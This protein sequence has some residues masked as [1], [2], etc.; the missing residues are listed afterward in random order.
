MRRIIPLTLIAL[1]MMGSVAL[2]DRDRGRR[3]RPG[4]VHVE[5]SRDHRAQRPDRRVIRNDRRV[6]RK[7]HRNDR[8]FVRDDRRVIRNDRRVVDRRVTVRR[9][10]PSF[11]DNRFYFPGGFYRT[12]QRPVINVR[13]TNYYQRPALLVENYDP[14]PGYV[15]VPGQ[16]T[17]TGYEWQWQPGHYEVDRS[18]TQSYYYD[19]QGGT[20]Y[21]YQY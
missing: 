17:W 4:G 19:Q 9:A 2:A 3:D 11:R 16:W 8:R 18:Y 13:Y 1:T 7:D 6:I 14:V 10:R 12:Y 15:W 5:R 21:H 20:Y